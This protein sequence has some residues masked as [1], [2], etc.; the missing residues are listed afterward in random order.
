MNRIVAGIP[1]SI[2]A[3][4]SLGV[5]ALL[6]HT[7]A[8]P[9]T[10]AADLQELFT[11]FNP[12]EGPSEGAATRDHQRNSRANWRALSALDYE[13]WELLPKLG[14]MGVDSLSEKTGHSRLD[15][16][17][18]LSELRLTGFASNVEGLWCKS[19]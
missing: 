1:G 15:L 12:R 11:G 7:D 3:P 2:H 4:T 5:N 13:V 16:L 18:R 17:A 9:V 8:H 6:K 10:S 19:K 14:G